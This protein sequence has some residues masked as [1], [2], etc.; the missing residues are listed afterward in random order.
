MVVDVDAVEPS[1]GYRSLDCGGMAMCAEADPSNFARGPVLFQN[2]HATT[3]SQCP[4]QLLLCVDSVQGKNVQVAHLHPIAGARERVP[5][6]DG[7]EFAATYNAN[8]FIDRV[9][10]GIA[11]VRDG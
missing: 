8:F 7:V 6:C 11:R 9:H 1:G 5:W 2:V 4:V 3:L 10:A